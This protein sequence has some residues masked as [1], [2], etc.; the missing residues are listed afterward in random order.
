MRK[1]T[2]TEIKAVVMI[3]MLAALA[4]AGL[5][6]QSLSNVNVGDIP[7]RACYQYARAG[8]PRQCLPYLNNELPVSESTEIADDDRGVWQ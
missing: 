8:R 1:H 3:V 2:E 5:G 7:S 6:C 4:A